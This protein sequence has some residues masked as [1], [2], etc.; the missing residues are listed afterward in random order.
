MFGEEPVV[1]RQEDE[2]REKAEA[3]GVEL[4]PEPRA[5]MSAAGQVRADVGRAVDHRQADRGEQQH[6][7][8]QEPVDVE[9]EAALEHL[10]GSP[11]PA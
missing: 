8:E 10:T 6:G 7:A 4:D 9:E 2:Q 3:G 5:G 1:E 11:R